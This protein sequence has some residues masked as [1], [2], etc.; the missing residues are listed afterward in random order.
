MGEV[1]GEEA[2]D[3]LGRVVARGLGELVRDTVG[4]A[5]A[6]GAEEGAS[7][8]DGAPVGAGDAVAGGRAAEL[9]G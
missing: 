5:D 3:T 6:V 7:D 8:A 9:A 4:C 2:G 1:V